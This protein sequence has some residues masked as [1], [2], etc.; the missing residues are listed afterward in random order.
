MIR[1]R[2]SQRIAEVSRQQRVEREE[3]ASQ[4]EQEVTIP[5]QVQEVLNHPLF[6]LALLAGLTLLSMEL[7]YLYPIIRNQNYVIIKNQERQ[8][9]KD[10]IRFLIDCQEEIFPEDWFKNPKW[11]PYKDAGDSYATIFL[12]LVRPDTGLEEELQ[13]V[14]EKE[15]DIT[16][17]D[18]KRQ[19]LMDYAI[20]TDP[21]LKQLAIE[22]KI[23]DYDIDQAII[24]YE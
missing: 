15:L 7:K 4:Q 20:N 12:N 22:G 2:I 23:K 11:T 19:F 17:P 1:D 16:N 18:V 3:R 6:N 5:E 8:Y 13:V 14:F 21:R 24:T 9:L 10:Q